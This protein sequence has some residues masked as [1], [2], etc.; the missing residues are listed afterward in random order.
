MINHDM[1]VHCGTIAYLDIYSGYLN[2]I[3][4][5]RQLK[6]HFSTKLCVLTKLIME[7]F[8][9]YR[10]IKWNLI[11]QPIVLLIM[12]SMCRSADTV[13]PAV[14]ASSQIINVGCPQM[15][16]KWLGVWFVCWINYEKCPFLANIIMKQCGPCQ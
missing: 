10:R 14:H 13:K 6:K 2:R 1:F 7:W 4:W 9:I 16:N 15:D 3:D 8:D 11:C 12:S 5:N